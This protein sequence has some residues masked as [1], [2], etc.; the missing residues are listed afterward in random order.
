M[1]V[2]ESVFNKAGTK[3]VKIDCGSTELDGGNLGDSTARVFD[4]G[5]V[6]E[7]IFSWEWWEHRVSMILES[8][9]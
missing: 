4:A 9:E 7:Q 8:S 2:A 1:L 6:P 5:N 3:E